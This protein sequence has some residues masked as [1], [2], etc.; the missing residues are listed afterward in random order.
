MNSLNHV[1]ERHEL[2]GLTEISSMKVVGNAFWK[3]IA[4]WPYVIWGKTPK[5]RR[6]FFVRPFHLACVA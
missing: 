3:L 4:P 2:N 6:I 1:E 5:W